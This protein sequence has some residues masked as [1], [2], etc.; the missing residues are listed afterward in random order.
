MLNV[1][2]KSSRLRV[3]KYLSQEKK[4]KSISFKLFFLILGMTNP[5][6]ILEHIEDIAKIMKEDERIYKFLHIPV[7][8]GS[9]IVLEDMKREYTIEEFQS[10]VNVMRER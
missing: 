4:F 6:Y 8:S 3:G 10:I 7:Q 1:L 9:N 5:P 2:P